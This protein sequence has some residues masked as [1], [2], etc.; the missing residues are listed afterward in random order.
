MKEIERLNKM[1][2]WV[3]FISTNKVYDSWIRDLKLLLKVFA[4]STIEWWC[5]N[6]KD[7]SPTPKVYQTKGFFNF[8]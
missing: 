6:I 4:L 8:L 5:D 3:P 1:R 7:A 2:V